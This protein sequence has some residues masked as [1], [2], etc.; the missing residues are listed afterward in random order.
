MTE[1]EGLVRGQ[2]VRNSPS[3]FNLFLYPRP[4]F[5][6]R[7]CPKKT[8]WSCEHVHH[9]FHRAFSSNAPIHAA[10]PQAS[11]HPGSQ[12]LHCDRPDTHG[13][14]GGYLPQAGPAPVP[15]YAQWVRALWC[16]ASWI[17]G[18]KRM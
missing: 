16:K 9:L 2:K 18:E 4:D 11:E 3:F 1:R 7:K 15:G 6:T 14:R 10:Y 12:P 8:G 17:W 5:S 13:D